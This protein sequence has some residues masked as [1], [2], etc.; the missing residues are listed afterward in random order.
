MTRPLL[1]HKI[2]HPSTAKKNTFENQRKWR[3]SWLSNDVTTSLADLNMVG[4][5]AQKLFDLWF[6]N[7]NDLLR[8]LIDCQKLASLISFLKDLIRLRNIIV[9]PAET[10]GT[11]T[12][13]GRGVSYIIGKQ[14]GT[15]LTY[16][17][18]RFHGLWDLRSPVFQFHGPSKHSF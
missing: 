7:C 3:T 11:S 12:E 8:L 9:N 17:L 1:L 10:D 16:P 6:G 14:A 2:P 15:N 4:G 13:M 18:G 5:S